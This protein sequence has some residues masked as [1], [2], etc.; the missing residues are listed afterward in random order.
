MYTGAFIENLIETV[1]RLKDAVQELYETAGLL[2]AVLD[3]EQR[4]IRACDFVSIEATRFEKAEIGERTQNC[5]VAMTRAA[6][7]LGQA[8][9]GLTGGDQPSP[10]TLSACVQALN[11][12]LGIL[13]EEQGLPRQILGHLAEGLARLAADCEKR[14]LQ[15]KPMVEANRFLVDSILHN[16][17]ESYRFWQDITEKTVVAYNAQGVQQAA[18]R[19]SAFRA[20]A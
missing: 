14:L 9:R 2:P 12:I 13:G 4:V 17:Q 3:K 16:V 5:F 6:D 19:N 20:K 8:R 15:V 11:D 1:S 18:G 10:V 7:Q